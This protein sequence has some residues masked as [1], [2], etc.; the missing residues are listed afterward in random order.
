MNHQITLELSENVYR[1]LEQRAIQQGKTPEA[2]ATEFIAGSVEGPDDDPLMKWAG[3]IDSEITDLGE[4]HDY[5][6]GQALA[7]ELDGNTRE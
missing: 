3:A 2:L 1:W 7:E 4:R 6:L 5:Y